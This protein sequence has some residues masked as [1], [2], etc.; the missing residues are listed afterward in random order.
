MG[1]DASVRDNLRRILDDHASSLQSALEMGVTVLVGSDAGSCGV[2]HGAGLLDEMR[3][4]EEAGMP[5]GQVLARVCGGNARTLFLE[6]DPP[7]LAAG[8]PATF[9]LAPAEVT[10]RSAALEGAFA[11]FTRR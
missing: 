10:R 1:W 2:T 9:I 3:L 11:L 5:V 4:L 8:D 7:P 6:T